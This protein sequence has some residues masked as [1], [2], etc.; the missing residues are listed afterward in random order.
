MSKTITLLALLAASVSYSTVALAAPTPDQVLAANEAATAPGGGDKAALK[1]SYDYAGQGLTGKIDSLVDLRRGRFVDAAKLGPANVANGFDGAHAWAKDPSGT[2]TVQDGGDQRQLAVNDSYRRANVWWQPDHGGAAIVNDGEKTDAGTIYDVLTV[3]PKDGKNFD[4]W[5]D[6]RTHL[7]SRLIEVQGTQTFTS[8]F[9][10]YKSVSGVELPV[11]TLVSNGDAKYDQHATLTAAAFMPAQPDA[12]FAMPKVTVADFSIAGG[13]E[14]TFPFRLINNHIFADVSINSKPFTFIFDTGGANLV[15]PATAQALGLQV[16]GQ[17]QANGAGTG[18]MDAGLTKVASLQLG[19]A[20]IKDQIFAVIPLDQMAPVEGVGMPGMI[21][22]ET[23]RRFVTRVD[24]GNGTL[25]LIDPKSFDP[26][27]A[28]T[29]VPFVFNGNTI[30]APAIYNG[31]QGTF[32]IDTGSRASLTLNSPFAAKNNLGGKGVAMVTGWGIGGPSRSL[33]LRGSTLQIGPYTINGPVVEV[34]TDKGGAFADASQSGNIG[35]G[36]L[37]RY[38]VTLDYEHMT[39]YLKP[40]TTAAADLDTFDRAGM[41][42]NQSA[43]GYAVVDVTKG[44][45]A[46]TAGLKT[47]DSIVAVD[48]KPATGIPVYEMRQRLRDEAPGT[49]V[50]FMVKSGGATKDVRVTLRDLI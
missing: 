2:I 50:T 43:D 22:F 26:K 25:T 11:D 29:P 44:S 8:R 1:L 21:G 30:E 38:V 28:G 20:T 49:S 14:T 15:T 24:Y 33:A 16:Q 6:A 36:I 17:M 27:D 3:T 45:P 46:E 48:G 4:A 7:L 19:K 34:S 5:F 42:F 40:A 12:A 10:G 18:H 35:A 39:L 32:T 37:K 9:S 47:G 41:W 13:G 23:F 31:V